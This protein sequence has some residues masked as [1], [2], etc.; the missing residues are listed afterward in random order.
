MSSKPAVLRLAHLPASNWV[1]CPS[2]CAPG[3]QRAS[4]HPPSRQ[5]APSG[6]RPAGTP[7]PPQHWRRWPQTAARRW[8][9]VAK[10][11]RPWVQLRGALSASPSC[12]HACL[13]LRTSAQPA[14]QRHWM[15][16]G[17]RTS[18]DGDELELYALQS[19]NQPLQGT[20]VETI[21]PLKPCSQAQTH[22]HRRN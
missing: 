4:P 21:K 12:R 19:E 18:G 9:H 8:G 10:V 14:R 7:Q 1:R 15:G 5:R 20:A 2:P 22:C 11:T 6:R 17:G 16:D 13:N 3:W